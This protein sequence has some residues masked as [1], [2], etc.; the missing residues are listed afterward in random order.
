VGFD[1]SEQPRQTTATSTMARATESSHDE[2]ALVDEDE[3]FESAPVA[4]PASSVASVVAAVMPSAAAGVP[5][6]VADDD[7][8]DMEPV[9]VPVRKPIIKKKVVASV[10][11]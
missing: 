3:V 5:E 9:P 1:P 7:A 10:K 11:K 6:S 2:T 8:E 4:K